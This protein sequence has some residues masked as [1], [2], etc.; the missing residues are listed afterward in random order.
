MPPTSYYMQIASPVF[1]FRLRF[2]GDIA[3]KQTVG[4][5]QIELSQHNS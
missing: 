3:V 5:Q 1:L 2:L 4:A